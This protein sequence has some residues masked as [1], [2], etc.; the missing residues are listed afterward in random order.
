V[1]DAKSIAMM[2]YRLGGRAVKKNDYL[3]LQVNIIFLL[4]ALIAATAV[5]QHPDWFGE[6]PK[7]VAPTLEVIASRSN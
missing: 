1:G 5:I 7:D 6:I 2:R 3:L 4:L